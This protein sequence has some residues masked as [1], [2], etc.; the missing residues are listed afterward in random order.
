MVF[1]ANLANLAITCCILHTLY[2]NTHLLPEEFRPSIAKRIGL[3]LAAG[4][5]ASIFG[6]VTNQTIQ[7][8]LAGT[9]FG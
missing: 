9:L 2:V 1:N 7:K 3:V 6:L 8:A 4:F 5:Y